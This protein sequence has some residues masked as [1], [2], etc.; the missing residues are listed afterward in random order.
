MPSPPHHRTS[1]SRRS[2][3]DR[4]LRVGI[5]GAGI[6]GLTAA[7]ELSSA[8]H[9]VLVCEAQS[10]LGGKMRQVHFPDHADAAGGIDSGPTVF[11]MRWVFDALFDDLG[12]TFADHVGLKP[13][14]V[15]ARHGWPDGSRLDLFADLERTVD[16]IAQF[17]GRRDGEAY[18]AFCRDAAA[19]FETLEAPFMA[20][21]KPS[22]MELSAR[23]MGRNP[24]GLTN[25][26]P[27]R[28]L[29]GALEARF[30]DPRLRQLFG[31]YATYTG[32]SPYQS[33][34]TLMLIAH[35][36]RRG[37]WMLDGGMHA[38]AQA[39]A[40]LATE[41]G[42]EIR[43]S[44]PVTD[45]TTDPDGRRVTGIMLETGEAIACDA[46]VFN[47]DVSALGTGRVNAIDDSERT[48]AH[49]T[50]RRAHARDV[51]GPGERSQSAMTWSALA[52][53]SPDVAAHTVAFSADYKAE[54]DATFMR[55]AL[56]SAPTV[57]LHAPD[58]TEHA[59]GPAA[60]LSADAE[61]AASRP[62]AHGRER[63]FA[64]TNAPANGD[65]A[66]YGLGAQER[67]FDAMCAS[68]DAC[69]FAVDFAKDAC[70]TTTPRDFARMFPGSGGALYGR[71][72]HGWQ[73]S[74]ER[75]GNASPIPGLYLCGGSV[76]PGAGVPMATLS[77]RL[78]AMALGIDA[79][80]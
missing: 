28:T 53:A 13:L 58:R 1:Q 29:A 20:A 9:D 78:A 56:P 7:L 65:T 36:E 54:F 39:F 62:S 31:R 15:L 33:P 44:A 42:A 52:Q 77:G 73:A 35:A 27:F 60:E 18:R 19:V 22:P 40:R 30:R 61:Q 68:L 72:P 70:V 12:L 74:F 17:A 6:G 67:A 80:R 43:L 76:H 34:A 8:G 41:R 3:S 21:P 38:L 46:V 64:L 45:I 47:G 10:T 51:V 59:H 32:G 75:A 63:I 57:Y 37:V 5:V 4:R 23:I 25:I 66:T 79:D 55:H 71:A 2:R 16:A 14:S 24:F 69:G 26:H 50:V 49:C 11:T 48:A